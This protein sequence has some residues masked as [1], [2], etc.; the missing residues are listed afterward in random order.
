MSD[1]DHNTPARIR[2]VTSDD[3]KA[4]RFYTGKSQMEGLT[5]ANV[6][7]YT[8]PLIIS[9]WVAL[10]CIMIEVLQWWP[11]PQLHGW[12]AYL[13]PIP[14]FA[15]MAL[16]IMFGIDWFNR[17]YFDD[18]L[19]E[20]IR[21]PDL[22]DIPAYYSRSPASGFWFLKYGDRFVGLIAIDASPDSTQSSVVVSESHEP[23]TK[24]SYGKGTAEIATIRHF[25]VDE[26]YR[27]VFIQDDLLQHAVKHAFQSS[28][29]VKCVRA[30]DSPLTPYLSQALKKSGFK[31]QGDVGSIGVLGWKLKECELEREQWKERT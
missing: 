17:P 1:N 18:K 3:Q 28:D 10:S 30:V 21:R 31:V 11:N 16:P 26:P 9:L 14:A 23:G 24:P 2:L 20:T 22:V 8:N 5:A 25:F 4:A 13:K 29:K 19:Q 27:A 15:A 6:K 12:T 7:L